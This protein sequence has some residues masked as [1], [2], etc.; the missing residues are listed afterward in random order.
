MKKQIPSRSQICEG[1]ENFLPA[2]VL[3]LSQPPPASLGWKYHEKGG[4]DHRR[5]PGP[6]H[7]VVYMLLVSSKKKKIGMERSPGWTM[8]RSG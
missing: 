8:L 5:C 3:G 7:W 6:V 1:K 4:S 2:S